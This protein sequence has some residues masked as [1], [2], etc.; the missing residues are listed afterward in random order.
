METLVTRTL[1]APLSAEGNKLKGYAVKWGEVA[2]IK[3]QY[4]HYFER[5]NRGS[6][7]FADDVVLS[8]GH[9]ETVHARTSAGNLIMRS[10]DIGVYFEA[11]LLPTT[12]AQDLLIEVGRQVVKGMSFHGPVVWRTVVEAG[13]KIREVVEGTIR[14]IC[15]TPY[16]AYAGTSVT[17]SRSQRDDIRRKIFLMEN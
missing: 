8:E 12:K 13:R 17:V 2:E 7:K 10:D 1:T 4:G 9:S 16:P 6:L 3:D 5:I 15:T 11:E 14:H